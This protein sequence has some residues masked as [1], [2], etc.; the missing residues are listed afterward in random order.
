MR[1]LLFIGFMFI[2]LATVGQSSATVYTEEWALY[3]GLVA[4]EMGV[5]EDLNYDFGRLDDEILEPRVKDW[6]QSPE[7]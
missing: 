7:V 5:Y 2:S 1:S 4:K 6:I 3:S